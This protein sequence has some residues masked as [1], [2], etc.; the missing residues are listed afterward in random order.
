MGSKGSRV[1]DQVIGRNV[2]RIR[3]RL[4]IS[5]GQLGDGLGLTFQQV[6]KYEKGLNRIGGSRV[7]QIADVLGC[8]IPDLFEGVSTAKAKSNGEPDPCLA[9]G[10]SR[11]G[12][13]MARAYGRLSRDMQHAIVEL[14]E[15][16]VRMGGPTS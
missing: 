2:R 4:G 8:S 13:R 6:Q 16:A 3:N 14:I 5:Q 10:T 15:H 12:V 9:L 11:L 1:E 7:V